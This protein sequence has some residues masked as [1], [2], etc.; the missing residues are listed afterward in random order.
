MKSVKSNSGTHNYFGKERCMK[1]FLKQSKA[2]T[3]FTIV[4]LLT[5]MA[6]IALLIGLLVPALNKVRAYGKEVK[7][8]AHLHSIEIALEM[9]KNDDGDY[10]PSC[11]TGGP[12]VKYQYSGAQTLT[13]ALLGRD[14]AGYHPDSVFRKDGKDSTGTFEVYDVDDP[15][16]RQARK[17]PYLELET[18]GVYM[19]IDMY[20]PT[21]TFLPGTNFVYDPCTYVLSDVFGRV[22]H[23]QTGKKIGMP[24]L[25]YKA[26]TAN[27]IH[28]ANEPVNENIYDYRDNLGLVA[29]GTPP[30][31]GKINPLND[32]ADGTDF[33]YFCEYTRNKK[34]PGHR[35]LRAGSYILI[36][37]GNDGLYGT[38]DDVCNFQK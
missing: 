34:L 7:Q 6:I 5:V 22:R 11:G 35:P 24:I 4:E 9:F 2:G 19:L 10:P 12:L 20:N 23:R 3:A 37:A 14:L 16:N 29:I 28:D 36:T 32:P 27:T 26:N 13:E 38:R 30:E 25:Y 21:G 33:T 1:K 18:A 17:G 15:V 8:K 31:K